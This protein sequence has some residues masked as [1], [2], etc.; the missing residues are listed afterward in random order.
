MLETAWVYCLGVMF[1]AYIV[2]SCDGVKF[3]Y[4]LF[5]LSFSWSGELSSP[6]GSSGAGGSPLSRVMTQ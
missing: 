6:A 3:Y 1:A 4:Y 2:L 5:S